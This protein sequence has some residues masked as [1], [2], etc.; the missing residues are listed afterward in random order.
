MDMDNAQGVF[1]LNP[2]QVNEVKQIALEGEIMPQKSTDFYPKLVS[3]MV[4]DVMM[5]KM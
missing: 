4:M 2:T 5:R 3:G 1:F